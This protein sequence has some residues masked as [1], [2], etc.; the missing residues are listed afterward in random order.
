MTFGQRLERAGI[1]GRSISA[2]SKVPVKAAVKA[3]IKITPVP[4]SEADEEMTEVDEEMTEVD[5]MTEI[6]SESEEGM[7]VDVPGKDEGRVLQPR[8]RV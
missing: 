5:E 8:M 2:P 4:G 1:K 6:E 7:D 3:P